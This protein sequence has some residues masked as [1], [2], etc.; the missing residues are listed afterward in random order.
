MKLAKLS[1]AA[2]VAVGTMTSFASATPL[3][4]A[5]KGVDF[6]GKVKFSSIERDSDDTNLNRSQA[7]SQDWDI[8]ATFVAPVADNLTATVGFGTDGGATQGGDDTNFQSNVTDQSWDIKSA[9]FTYAQD[10]VTVMAGHQGIPGPIDDNDGNGVV[11]MY[12]AGVATLAAMYF[13]NTDYDPYGTDEGLDISGIAAM[14]SMG[15]VNAQLWVAQV[16]DTVDSLVFTQ[17]DGGM[18]GFTLMAQYIA[19][20]LNDR[21]QAAFGYADDSGSFWGLQVGYKYENMNFTAKYVDIDVDQPV[22]ALAGDDDTG[23]IGVGWRIQN[24]YKSGG[25]TSAENAYGIDASATFGKFNVGLGYAVAENLGLVS[26]GTEDDLNEVYGH[27]KY[28]YS[29][30]FY[31][32]VKAGQVDNDQMTDD[33]NLFYFETKYS[34]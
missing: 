14:G 16:Q 17:L 31:G 9:Y 11:A 12:D 2:I 34:F 3:E 5:I 13:A 23:V 10:G 24:D 21:A 26:A 8:D 27:V 28:S 1:L 6:S 4:E 7:S 15:P 30:N 33:E 18:A 25:G 29:K 22:H 19:T 32:L 20:K